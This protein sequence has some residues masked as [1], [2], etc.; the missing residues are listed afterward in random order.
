MWS[1]VMVALAGCGGIDAGEPFGGSDPGEAARGVIPEP[2]VAAPGAS[3]PVVTTQVLHAQH[4]AIPGGMFGGWG[5]HLGHLVRLGSGALWFVDDACAPGQCA[6]LVNQR[7]DYLRLDAGGWKRID[8]QALPSGIQQNTGSIAVGERLSSFG[9]DSAGRRVIECVYQNGA[10]SCAAIPIDIGAAANYVGA[11]VSPGRSRMVWYTN[12]VDGGGGSFSFLAN[13]GGGWNGP[14]AGAIGGYN[15]VSYIHVAFGDDGEPERFRMHGELV[16]GLAPNWSFTVGDGR[17][18]LNQAAPVTWTTPLQAFSTDDIAIDPKTGGS[19][20][21]VRTANG[22]AV[23]YYRPKN[24]SFGGPLHVFPATYRARLVFLSDGTLVL[25]RGVSKGG[26]AIQRA[27]AGK[28][29]DWK[30]VAEL[31]PS[32]PSGYADLLAIYPESSIYQSA[33]V[34]SLELALVGSAREHEVLHLS[35]RF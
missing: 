21:L 10:K 25:A 13:Y 4:R 17:G 6:V 34:D 12:V 33:P 32:L 31:R 24:G 15:D 26:L 35:A 7:V 3:A 18:H 5:P 28:A 11:A 19:H 22:S 2:A 20:L 29:V 16:A 14:R 9:I 1:W 27:P 23:Y 30:I 8:S